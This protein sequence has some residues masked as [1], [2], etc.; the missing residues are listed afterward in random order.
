MARSL[1]SRVLDDV[2]LAARYTES[3]LHVSTVVRSVRGGSDENTRLAL[4]HVVALSHRAGDTVVLYV[5]DTL[6]G[7]V[8]QAHIVLGESEAPRRVPREPGK[9]E[10]R[11]PWCTYQTLRMRLSV[12]TVTCINPGCSDSLGARPVGLFVVD[13]ISG[14]MAISWRDGTVGLPEPNEMMESA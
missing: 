12:G 7:W 1:E 3:Q 6:G 14:E 10:P 13:P 5:L 8:S 4:E 11:C 2:R 9:R